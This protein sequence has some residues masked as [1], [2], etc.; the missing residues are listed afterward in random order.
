M[1]PLAKPLAV[2][3]TSVR[4]LSSGATTGKYLPLEELIATCSEQSTSA[5]DS[6]IC[7]WISSK[8]EHM[9]VVGSQLDLLRRAMQR[10][11]PKV[12]VAM[13]LC[14]NRGRWIQTSGGAFGKSTGKRTRSSKRPPSAEASS[15]KADQ[16]SKPRCSVE[17]WGKPMATSHSSSVSLGSHRRTPP[18]ASAPGL[19]RLSTC[20]SSFISRNRS[21]S[22]RCSRSRSCLANKPVTSLGH[23]PARSFLRASTAFA[24]LSRISSSGTLCSDSLVEM[25]QVVPSP[26][27][28]NRCANCATEATAEPRPSNRSS[29][30]D[31]TASLPG[32]LNLSAG[33]SRS[34][35]SLSSQSMVNAPASPLTAEIVALYHLPFRYW[36]STQSPNLKSWASGPFRR[37]AAC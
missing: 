15:A 1:P 31:R 22:G 6:S 10:R 4:C 11:P 18:G 8:T 19:S 30:S 27:A 28:S 34:L 37:L 16:C 13:L 26:S 17:S 32:Y 35:G 9:D 20:R 2:G 5:P 7:L 33:F 21:T 36:H 23:A 3:N 29:Q 12:T 24:L 25:L 14:F